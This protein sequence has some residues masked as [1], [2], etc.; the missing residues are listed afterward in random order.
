MTKV[1]VAMHA[2]LVALMVARYEPMAVVV[3][4][5]VSVDGLN[6]MPAGSPVTVILV[7]PLSEM[8]FENCVFV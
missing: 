5:M 1:F 6:V 7:W 3:P 8:A 4:L 2:P